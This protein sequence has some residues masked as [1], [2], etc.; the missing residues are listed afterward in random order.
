MSSIL[1]VVLSHAV[2]AL[3]SA[4]NAPSEKFS[5]RSFL[6]FQLVVGASPVIFA[7]ALGS[8]DGPSVSTTGNTVIIIRPV[9]SSCVG[10]LAGHSVVRPS[11]PICRITWPNSDLSLVHSPPEF[12]L[13]N[14]VSFDGRETRTARVPLKRS[15]ILAGN[16]DYDERESM[17]GI[18]HDVPK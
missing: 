9:Q 8:R 14:C 2:Y 7:D 6:I 3:R 4:W 18:N 10:R 17:Q 13:I 5:Q 12:G 1:H 15:P 16:R 11:L